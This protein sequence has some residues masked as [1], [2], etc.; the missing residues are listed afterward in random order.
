MAIRTNRIELQSAKL[1]KELGYAHSSDKS[2]TEYKVTQEHDNPSFRMTVGEISHDTGYFVNNHDLIDFSCEAYTQYAHPTHD[3]MRRWL[4]MEYNVHMVCIPVGKEYKGFLLFG[5]V[6]SIDKILDI[7]LDDIF[8]AAS[9]NKCL[10]LCVWRALMSVG[11]YQIE[12]VK[13]SYADGV[14]GASGEE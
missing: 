13:K 10:D 1:A 7:K 11:A 6:E 9:Y 4:V 8:T 14:V 12:E 5:S 3:E 2:I